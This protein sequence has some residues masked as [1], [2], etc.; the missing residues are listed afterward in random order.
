MRIGIVDLGTLSLRFDVYELPGQALIHKHRSMP[1]LGDMLFAT[2]RIDPEAG[3]RVVSELKLVAQQAAE[4]IVDKLVCVG[5]SALR[6]AANGAE[7]LDAV[8]KA[9]GIEITIL[10]G[11]DEA[12][13]TALGIFANEPSL[14]G[15][16]ALVDI[17]GGS[18]EISFV[19][20]R[21]VT[22][23]ISI[24]LGALRLQKLFLADRDAASGRYFPKQIEQTRDAIRRALVSLPKTTVEQVVGS[25]GTIRTLERL[26]VTGARD[27]SIIPRAAID[28]FAERL[29]G[30]TR[31]ECLAIP[32]MEENR[33]DVILPGVLI[34]AEI[35]A[36]LNAE[37]VF[38]THYS[39]RHGLL[40]E[41]KA[42]NHL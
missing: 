30:L 35:L 31:E 32:K 4:L 20:A 9:S 36:A 29:I 7:L 34:L 33:V 8:K 18:T 22:E 14:G 39:L 26:G 6:D 13:L 11:G 21:K 28:K 23:S 37:S 38:V 27:S 16:S 40:E 19:D 5:T 17:G 15:K 3:A 2:G 41:N 42:H 24:D 10:S 1:R 12:R 25:S